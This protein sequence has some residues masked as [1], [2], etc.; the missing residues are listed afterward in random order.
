MN[1]LQMIFPT[2]N[3]LGNYN[4][5]NSFTIELPASFWWN[6]ANDNYSEPSALLIRFNIIKSFDSHYLKLCLKLTPNSVQMNI[7]A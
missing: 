7:R 3:I 6:F 1:F 2:G 4:F 5:D